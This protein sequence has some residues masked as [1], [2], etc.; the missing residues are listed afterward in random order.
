[1]YT[2]WV[3]T[4][5]GFS[6]SH[7]QPPDELKKYPLFKE[8]EIAGTFWLPNQPNYFISGVLT[9]KPGEGI[10]IGIND[11]PWCDSERQG[12]HIDVIQGCLADGSKCTICNC[13]A[14][15]VTYVRE[16]KYH[17][18]TIYG[19]YM[20]LGKLLS[21]LQ[22]F[23]FSDLRCDFTHLNEWCENPYRIEHK[24]DFRESLV[25]FNPDEFKIELEAEGV[26]FQLELFCSHS[27]P[28]EMDDKGKNWMYNYCLFIRPKE[29]QGFEWFLSI[30]LQLR[31]CLMF[32]IGAA[33][34]TL[35]LVASFPKNTAGTDVS[36]GQVLQAVDVP[37][38]IRSNRHDFSTR[39]V[40]IAEQLP[41]ILKAWFNC[42]GELKV[43][44][45]TYKEM[46]LNDGSY[47]ESLF[48]R[49]VQALEHFHGVIF[50][51]DTRYLDPKAWKAFTDLVLPNV[52]QALEDI[53]YKNDK[54]NNKKKILLD[55]FGFLN[56]IS[57]MSRLKKLI[58]EIPGPELMPLLNNPDNR[59]KG[60]DEFV[61]KIDKT[62]NF[63]IHHEQKHAKGALKSHELRR[64]I[65]SYWAI[66]SY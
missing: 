7:R 32:L 4:K 48:L 5:G 46:L 43:I 30:A 66:L 19:E 12:I 24:H 51:K 18:S 14:F 56:E 50:P 37:S 49:I 16:R 21:N 26:S 41:Q 55:R 65:S 36:H 35:D 13:R 33:I 38:A 9:F 2:Y 31:G 57:F 63:L 54:G 58:N 8:F 47:E 17:R 15:I 11:L 3:E 44:M 23:V 20:V 53:G 6:I 10:L 25:S 42:A 59:E 64:A 61:R 28:T 27:I 62:R 34:Y 1:M 39:Y 45:N 60:I 22:D 40:E 52:T 29:P